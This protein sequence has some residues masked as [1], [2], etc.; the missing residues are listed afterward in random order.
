MCVVKVNGRIR[1]LDLTANVGASG[2]LHCQSLNH[3]RWYFQTLS[4]IPISQNKLLVFN[5]L[6]S[7][8]AGKYFCYGLLYDHS[9]H[10]L[11]ETVLRVYG[12]CCLY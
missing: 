5:R 7:D 8:N 4:S 3:T 9:K 11:T 1:P 12:Q 10:F 2:K 6:D